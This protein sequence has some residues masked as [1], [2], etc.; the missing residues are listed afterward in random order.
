[1]CI[2]R[3]DSISSCII[4]QGTGTQKFNF[5]I[6][7]SD[8]HKT[9]QHFKQSQYSISESNHKEK[10]MSGKEKVNVLK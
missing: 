2:S 8:I 6:F 1:M 7:F 10:A 5:L 3:H 9:K 4:Q